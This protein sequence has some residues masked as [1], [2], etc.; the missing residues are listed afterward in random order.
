MATLQDNGVVYSDPQSKAELINRA[1]SAVF[2]S[3]DTS[4]MP[5]LSDIC[6]KK[7]HPL[8]SIQMVL[9]N[10]YKILNQLKLLDLTKFQPFFCFEFA[11]SLAMIYKASLGQ[12][13]LPQEWKHANIVP[14]YKKDDRSSPL[15]YRPV[16]LTC[17]CCKFF[18]HI[19]STS[20]ST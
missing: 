10:F 14:I 7:F 9:F 16:S 18:E 8:I 2:T 13:Q 12:G 6:I 17:I 11:P 19:C 20:L 5:V 4:T 3:E 1:F 15:N